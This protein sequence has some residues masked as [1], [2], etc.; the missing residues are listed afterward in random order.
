[1]A[2]SPILRVS[3]LSKSFR[4]LLALQDVTLHLNPGEILGVIG[5]N[6]AGKTTL[7]N[8]LTG[9]VRPT[10]GQILFRQRDLTRLRTPQIVR[11]GMARTFQN[12]RLFGAM[13]VLDNV[14]VA[15]QLHVGFNVVEVLSQSASFRRKERDLTDKALAHLERFGLAQD[16]DQIAANLPYTSI[17]SKCPAA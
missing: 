5:P 1:M 16:A 11:L 9:Y 6:G 12:I 3:N 7:F 17:N 13:S 10:Q 8:C 4:G 14:R 15:Q 2:T